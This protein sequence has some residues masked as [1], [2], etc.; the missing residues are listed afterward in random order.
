MSLT[1]IVFEKPDMTQNIVAFCDKYLNLVGNSEAHIVKNLKLDG[2]PVLEI[3]EASDSSFLSQLVITALKVG[4]Y[5]TVILPA[6]ALVIKIAYYST[7]QYKILTSEE[8]S[9]L[10]IDNE[11]KITTDHINTLKNCFSKILEKNPFDE[12]TV[13]KHNGYTINYYTGRNTVFSIEGIPEFVFKLA[14]SSVKAKNRINKMLEA[15]TVCRANNLDLLRI[16]QTTMIQITHEGTIYDVVIEE[17][18]PLV[19]NESKQEELFQLRGAALNKAFKQLTVFVCLTKNSDIEFRNEPTILDKPDKNG[20]YPIALVDL[21]ETY[22]TEWGLFGNKEYRR[23]G[24]I[25][26]ANI[27]QTEIIVKTAMQILRYKGIELDSFYGDKYYRG[28]Y[29]AS[30]IP[31]IAKYVIAERE[32]EMEK[33]EDLEKFH[34]KKGIKHGKEQIEVR[35][36]DDDI[37]SLQQ[38]TPEEKK[39]MTKEDLKIFS[40]PAKKQ[41]K[42]GIRF[43]ETINKKIASNPDEAS[44]KGK[45]I[46]KLKGEEYQQAP[47]FFQRFAQILATKGAIFGIIARNKK[48]MNIQC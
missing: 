9:R 19:P 4:T 20:N 47:G 34:K 10:E 33:I 39:Q 26:L 30:I 46:V 22:S 40:K 43:I 3:R 23:R 13:H 32:A 44:L 29:P 27:A 11:I 38:L 7:H 16:P 36:T 31:K 17:K 1:P 25:R 35:I 12:V 48:S 8:V 37:A 14:K 28:L 15:R 18:L 24:L 21:E 6:I 2:L 42:L 45:R 5:M 41:K